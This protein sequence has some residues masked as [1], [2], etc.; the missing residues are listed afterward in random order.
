MQPTAS[1]SAVEGTG[2]TVIKKLKR[3]PIS[4]LNG[5]LT[6]SNHSGTAQYETHVTGRR[7]LDYHL[8]CLQQ[9]VFE[10]EHGGGYQGD[11]AIDDVNIT[12]DDCPGYR[13]KLVMLCF[14]L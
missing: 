8:C 6:R 5:T 10:A 12:A 13:K 9:V 7:N 4:T 3:S 2:V 14:F 1:W 11:I